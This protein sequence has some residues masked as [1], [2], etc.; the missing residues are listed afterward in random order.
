MT[1]EH[2]HES[3]SRLAGELGFSP[4]RADGREYTRRMVAR[5][6]AELEV[7]QRDEPAAT[8]CLAR[9]D[10][11]LFVGLDVRGL[12]PAAA[13]LLRAQR[14]VEMSCLEPRISRALLQSAYRAFESTLQDGDW[15]LDVVDDQVRLRSG[16][17]VNDAAKLRV[18]VD[19]AA[20]IAALLLEAR[21]LASP[22][23]W[24]ELLTREWQAAAGSL[25]ARLEPERLS[26]VWP[27]G[28]FEVHARLC[29]VEGRLQTHLTCAVDGAAP[30]PTT[31]ASR[32]IAELEVRGF[33][34]ALFEG[35]FLARTDT[36][37]ANASAL[38]AALEGAFEIAAAIALARPSGPYRG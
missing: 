19:V 37:L 17:I 13:T 36:L 16:S 2:A 15:M 25:G 35:G 10:P 3:W 26:I 4:A 21:R 9:L 18:A 24:K 23:A 7:L 28:R 14:Q 29:Y 20:R 31:E 22:P 11:P 5:Q 27:I 38:R 12:T 6:G 33:T 30:T 1:P 8:C 34:V 32:R